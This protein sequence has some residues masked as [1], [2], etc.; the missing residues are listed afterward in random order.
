MN[1]NITTTQVAMLIAQAKGEGGYKRLSDK[2]A[3]LKQLEAAVSTRFDAGTALIVMEELNAAETWA[4]A[5]TKLQD[6]LSGSDAIATGGGNIST[7]EERVEPTEGETA[8][9]EA[10]ADTTEKPK[11]K[12]KGGGKAPKEPK[13]PKAPKEATAAQPRGS[14]SKKI[15][16]VPGKDPYREG[17]KSGDTWKLIKDQPGKTFDEYV[18]LGGRA[19]TISDAIRKGWVTL[20]D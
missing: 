6:R 12:G 2:K 10:E 20:S 1:P 3:G 14:R 15:T 7:G 19:N 17:T 4:D 9:A 5:Q 8:D 11:K 13:A 16:V 18:K